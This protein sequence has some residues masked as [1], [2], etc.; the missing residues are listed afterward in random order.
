MVAFAYGRFLVTSNAI[1][2]PIMIMTMMI[3]MPM[4]SSA[5]CVAKPLSG[6]DV[7]ACVGAGALA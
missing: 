4:Y 5:F 6:V 1:T 2:A 3:A 7:G